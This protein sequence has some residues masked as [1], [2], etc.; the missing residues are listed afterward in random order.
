[1]NLELG[2][3]YTDVAAEKI[4][5]LAQF[6]ERHHDEQALIAGHSWDY[7]VGGSGTD[8]IL[9]LPGVG[10]DADTLFRYIAGFEDYFHIIAP[11]LPPSI[12]HLEDAVMGLHALLAI[13]KVRRVHV[14]GMSLGGALAQFFVRRFPQVVDDVVITHTALPDP[15]IAARIQMQRWFFR[16]LPAPTLRRLLQRSFQRAIHH[17]AV[18]QIAAGE[19]AF[20]QAYFAEFYA[21]R[22]RKDTFLAR[23]RLSRDYYAMPPFQNTDLQHWKGRVLIIESEQDEVIDEGQ[24]GALKALYPAAYVQT[25]E[26]HGHL[27]TLLA[28]DTLMLSI[29][30]F[31]LMQQEN[32]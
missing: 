28:S 11:N 22:F 2:T 25:L 1:M 19:R 3:F 4:Q 20:W 12:R 32:V 24:R 29:R 13:E 9:L 23:V 14:V 6:R 21:T 16:L 31:L 17:A 27:A 7:L 26:Q 10:G 30:K 8:T 18:P 5:A 15:E